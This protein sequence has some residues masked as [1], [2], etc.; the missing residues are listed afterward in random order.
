[1]LQKWTGGGHPG[2]FT[3]EGGE[4]KVDGITGKEIKRDEKLSLGTGFFRISGSEREF[5]ERYRRGEGG[6][7]GAKQRIEVQTG[8]NYW[9]R[10]IDGGEKH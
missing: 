10:I 5:K 7:D 6:G 3:V 8:K 1:M 2:C 4:R 9:R